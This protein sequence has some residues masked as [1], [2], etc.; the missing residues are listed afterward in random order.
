MFNINNFKLYL[1]INIKF[2]KAD[3]NFFKS[4]KRHPVTSEYP[5]VLL[6]C[7]SLTNDNGIRHCNVAALEEVPSQAHDV[8]IRSTEEVLLDYGCL[9]TLIKIINLNSDYGLFSAAT[10][11]T[12]NNAVDPNHTIDRIIK[13]TVLELPKQFA[14]Q[15]EDEFAKTEF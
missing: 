8:A 4:I 14:K 9:S 10:K 2:T 3:N 11:M 5:Q 6:H 1:N 7:I 15:I 12:W 13:R